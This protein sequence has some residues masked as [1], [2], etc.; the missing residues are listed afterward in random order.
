[1]NLTEESQEIELLVREIARA[2]VDIPEAVRLEAQTT[3]RATLFRLRVHP[4]EAGKVIGKQGRNAR[5]VRILLSAVSAKLHHQFSL[6]IIEGE[7]EQG[8][9]V[10]A[11]P[12]AVQV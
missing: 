11:T 7:R 3:D 6:E 9:A 1:M 4:T 8:E 5:A 10:A 12:A 2:L